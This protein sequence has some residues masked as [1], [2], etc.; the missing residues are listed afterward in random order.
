MMFKE[1]KEKKST[2]FNCYIRPS[3]ADDISKLC[4]ESNI[5]K[6]VFLEKAF[7]FFKLNGSELI[8]TDDVVELI[9]LACNIIYS[10]ASQEDEVFAKELISNYFKLG[11]EKTLEKMMIKQ[12]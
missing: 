11:K 7:D 8:Q 1:K 4:K 12:D 3:L 5:S 9:K 2:Q 6:S 10:D